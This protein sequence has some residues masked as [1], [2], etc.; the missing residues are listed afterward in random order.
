MKGLPEDS[1]CRRIFG[2]REHKGC[3]SCMGDPVQDGEELHEEQ[4]GGESKTTIK[5]ES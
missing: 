1:G 2:A 3:V 4:R 5:V